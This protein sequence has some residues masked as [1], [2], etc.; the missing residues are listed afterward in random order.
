MQPCQPGSDSM[1]NTRLRNINY[2]QSYIKLIT[3]DILVLECF[4]VFL[5][6]LQSIVVLNDSTKVLIWL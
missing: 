2:S 4:G 3:R 1:N 5:K 6:F